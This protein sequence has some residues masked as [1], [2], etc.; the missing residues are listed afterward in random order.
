M[1]NNKVKNMKIV[2]VKFDDGK[3]INSILKSKGI[4]LYFSMDY[5]YYLVEKQFEF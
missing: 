4:F 3:K 5:K 2:S 1:E